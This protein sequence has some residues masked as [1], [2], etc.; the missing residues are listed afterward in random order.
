[1]AA[2][3]EEVARILREM[4]VDRLWAEA[5]DLERRRHRRGVAGVDCHL[6][7][8]ARGHGQRVPRLNV[9][10]EEVGLSGGWQ[11]WVSEDRPA[12]C[13][14]QAGDSSP[15]KRQREL[16]PILQA[17]NAWWGGAERSWPPL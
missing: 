8:P 4:G 2:E 1:M 14:T 3:F 15:G 11:T 17:R 12:E 16:H 5:S 13:A 6:P 9:T 10:L 7:G